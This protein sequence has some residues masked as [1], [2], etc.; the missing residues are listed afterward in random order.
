[1]TFKY[2]W[3][4]LEKLETIYKSQKNLV[5]IPKNYN[6]LVLLLRDALSYQTRLLIKI[7]EKMRADTYK[8]YSVD[9]FSYSGPSGI[10]GSDGKQKTA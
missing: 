5:G 8:I 10:M 9:I 3:I 2:S 7:A 1:M 6:L 4:T